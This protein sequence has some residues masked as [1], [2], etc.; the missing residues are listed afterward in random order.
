V[1]QLATEPVY[2][3]TLDPSGEP[4]DVLASDAHDAPPSLLIS[5]LQRPIAALRGVPNLGTWVGVVLSAI[6]LVL[7]AVAWGRTAGLV[8]VALQVPYV[9]SAAFTGLGL[10]V[11]GLAIVSISSKRADSEERTRQIRELREAL[12]DLRQTL[13][14][15]R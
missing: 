3:P 9:V 1:T 2:D 11:V 15:G 4:E 5:R 8:N 12:A 6:G 10:V 7:I 14:D 13:E